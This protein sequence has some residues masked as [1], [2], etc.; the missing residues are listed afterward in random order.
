M[1][2]VIEDDKE[3]LMM[4]EGFPALVA[5]DAKAG[6]DLLAHN[7]VTKVMCDFHGIQKDGVNAHDVVKFCIMN[8]IPCVL[9]SN[10]P[11]TQ[12]EFET[13]YG[14]DCI[15][16]MDMMLEIQGRQRGAM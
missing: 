6:L 16:K 13:K 15:T 12:A 3:W 4:M 2:L 9:T 1:I 10:D 5:T 8:S 11:F 14:I 7:A